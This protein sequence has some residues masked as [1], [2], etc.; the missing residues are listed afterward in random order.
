MK[1]YVL[2][3]FAFMT[4]CAWAQTKELPSLHVEG[5]WLV[6]KHGNQVVLHG[7][8]DTPNMYFNGWRW[9]SPWD[10]NNR[11]N[12]DDGS[13]PKCLDYFE[14]LFDAME[15]TNCDVFRL[16]MDPAWTND[17]DW[18]NPS[19]P[20]DK[21]QGESDIRAFSESRYKNYLSLLYLELAKKAMKHGLYVVVRPPGVCPQ[22]IKVGD[23]Y[24]N[25]LMLIW[26]IFSQQ[27]YV[28]QHAGQISI[29]LA[30]EPVSVKNA[31]NQD[32]SKALHDFFQPIVDKIRTNGFTGIIWV[33]GAGYQSNYRS[34]KTN[35]ITGDNIGYAVHDYPGWYSSSD[36]NPD[37]DNKIAQFHDA[38]PVVDTN[39]IFIT[40][41][42]WSPEKEPKVIAKNADGTDKKNEF[43]QP[44]YENLGTWATGSTSKWGKAYKAMLDYFQNISMTLT[45]PHDFLDLDALYD[46]NII[47]AAFN[48]NPEACAKTCMDWY[49]EYIKVNNAHPDDEE[50]TGDAYTIE[51]LTTAEES[52][53][54]MIGEQQRLSLNVLFKDGHKKEVAGLAAYSVENPAIAKVQNG[55]IC[56]LASGETTITATY[57]YKG[58]EWKKAISIKV[59]GVSLSDFTA[60]SSLDEI[61]AQPFAIMA[62]DSEKMFFGSNNQNLGFE[63]AL[64]VFNDKSIN[65]YMF[66]AEPLAGNAGC[67]LLRLIT[68]SG[69]EYSIWGSPGYLNSQPI[70]G[71]CCFILG[72]N[73]QNGQDIK[74]GAVW[75]IKYEAGKGFTM[76]N[77]GTGMYLKTN[78]AAKYDTPTYM[79]FLKAGTSTG[80]SN[81]KTKVA[82]DAV[83]NLHGVKVGRSDQMET[84]PRGIYIIGGKKV[85]KSF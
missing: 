39:P 7:V 75:E 70:S 50:E 56:A 16:H 4:L 76:K 60:L 11:S 41:V 49:A 32:D 36:D 54:L 84:L 20:D 53:D 65:G 66:K 1:R 33:P 27:E 34:Y 22:Q 8:M 15:K 80:I 12:Y 83:Y 10:A 47:K 6:D 31:N 45:H 48:G 14:T 77:K 71:G 2:V 18:K 68:L 58:N 57:S 55:Y 9:G 13:V 3:F 17:P 79:D 23:D 29:E 25:Y 69:S 38:V 42:D 24:N 81:I 61:T 67:Y 85:V 43:G 62:K 74:D 52:Y 5:R 46:Q 35:P 28:K 30:N 19:D 44:V 51:S 21:I 72:L 78:D 59:T 64:A 63:N 73:S 82:D 26:D 37:P 40:E